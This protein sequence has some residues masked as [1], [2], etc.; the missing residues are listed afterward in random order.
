MK[1]CPY[2][3]EEIQDEAVKCK[4]CG[5]A[6]NKPDPL[7]KY[8][9]KYSRFGTYIWE[10]VYAKSREEAFEKIKEMLKQKYPT[11]DLNKFEITEEVMQKIISKRQTS[12]VGL[13]L[14]LLGV[15]LL[16]IF[17]IGT[18]FGIAF[19]ICGFNQSKKNVCSECGNKIEDKDIKICPFCKTLFV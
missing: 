7:L 1:K 5:E 12:V 3:A 10:D 8:R 13:L 19:L 2:C 11:T 17:P 14:E 16:F 6:L 9:F 4:H 15:V 18:I